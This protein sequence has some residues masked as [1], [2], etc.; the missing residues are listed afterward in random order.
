MCEGLQKSLNSFTKTIKSHIGKQRTVDFIDI[1]KTWPLYIYL[2]VN[3]D[4]SGIKFADFKASGVSLRSQRV[5][6]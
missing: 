5:S 1:K 4:Q 6:L 3:P 2:Q